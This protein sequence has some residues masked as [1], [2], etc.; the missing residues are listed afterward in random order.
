MHNGVGKTYQQEEIMSSRAISY[1]QSS[2]QFIPEECL[3]RVFEF[4]D[5][6]NLG[7]VAS[8]CKCFARVQTERSLWI[9]LFPPLKRFQEDPLGFKKCAEEFLV[10]LGSKETR[11]K[12]VLDM[13]H[14]TI[15]LT[16][17]SDNAKSACL[18]AIEHPNVPNRS[19]VVYIMGDQQV[20][21]AV[22]KNGQGVVCIVD[23]I[24]QPNDDLTIRDEVTRRTVSEIEWLQN[25]KSKKY[26]E[27][28]LIPDQDKPAGEFCLKLRTASRLLRSA[29]PIAYSDED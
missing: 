25:N 5:L 12:C 3:V 7:R 18:L 28:K 6:K 4:L 24:R 11:N 15:T 22:I 9:G 14:K 8:I 29:T 2:L 10:P 13:R 26:R 23:D 21:C 17:S 1:H 19:F 27:Y 16:E 20:P